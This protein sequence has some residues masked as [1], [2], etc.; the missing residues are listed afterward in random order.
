MYVLLLLCCL[1]LAV[2]REE[3]IATKTYSEL[4]A[5]TGAHKTGRINYQRTIDT[6][7]AHCVSC[8]PGEQIKKGYKAIQ[9]KKVKSK[10]L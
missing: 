9:R 2:G 6:H 7:L 3:N 5:G 10:E 4:V 1:S 8:G